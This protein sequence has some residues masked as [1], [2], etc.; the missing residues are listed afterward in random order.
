MEFDGVVTRWRRLLI[1]DPREPDR[2]I[3]GEWADAVPTPVEGAW[4]ASTS[5]AATRSENRLQV[6]TAKS[7]FLDDPEADVQAGDG[8]SVRSGADGPEYVVEAVPEADC[9]PFT[10]W[11]PVREVP[12]VSY[13]G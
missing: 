9:N 13:R 5:S 12:L 3:P 10:G 11:Q 7:L 6:M 4:V 8:I 1:P 2:M